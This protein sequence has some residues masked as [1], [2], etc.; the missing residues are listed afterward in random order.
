MVFVGLVR[1]IAPAAYRV[2]V[3]RAVNDEEVAKTLIDAVD[4]SDEG[5]GA[6]MIAELVR[7][8]RSDPSRLGTAQKAIETVSLVRESEKSRGGSGD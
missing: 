2:L 5:E 6:S 1:H 3:R 4:L 8:V 7:W